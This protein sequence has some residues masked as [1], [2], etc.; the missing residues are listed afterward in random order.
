MVD[1][2]FLD[3]GYLVLSSCAPVATPTP[4]PT[5]TPIP[6]PTPTPIPAPTPTPAPKGPQYGGE[7]IYL[8]DRAMNDFDDCY[9]LQSKT[10][11]LPLTNQSLLEGNWAKGMAGTGE[12]SWLDQAVFDETLEV[13]CV[14]EA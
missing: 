6:T 2:E 13:G 9:Q 3:G 5:L 8:D 12:A 7:L 4:T 11:T 1:F 10:Y 14:A